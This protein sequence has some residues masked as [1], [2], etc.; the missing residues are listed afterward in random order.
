MPQLADDVALVVSELAS[1]V[2]TH[3]PHQVG[4]QVHGFLVGVEPRPGRCVRVEVHDCVD[5]RPAAREAD[6]DDEGGRGLFLVEAVSS[7]WGVC[8]R[9]PFGKIIWAEVGGAAE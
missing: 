3:V 8:L 6:E 5:G 7:R 4:G 9:T 1:N 2:I